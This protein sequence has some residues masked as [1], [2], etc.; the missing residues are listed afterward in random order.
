MVD[1]CPI[2]SKRT[3]ILVR[4]CL[5]PSVHDKTLTGHSPFLKIDFGFA[6]LHE[7]Q[8]FLTRSTWGT[9]YVYW[10]VCVN[11]SSQLSL[12]VYSEYLSPER[13]KG[14]LHDARLA[15]IWSL[16]VTYFEIAVGR[17]P[18]EYFNETVS[19]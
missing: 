17:S 6:A 19:E 7:K 15:D 1:V 16:G 8:T 10:L 18:F 9:P 14:M 2:T 4:S 5:V 3:P 12:Y 13:Y 11:I